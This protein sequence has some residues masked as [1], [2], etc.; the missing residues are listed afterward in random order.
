VFNIQIESKDW[1]IA[2]HTSSMVVGMK[3]VNWKGVRWEVNEG[4]C[5]RLALV[6]T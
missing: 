2:I 3:V 4:K 5:K 1:W 6:E